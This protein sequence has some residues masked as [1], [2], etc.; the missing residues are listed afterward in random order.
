M[1][2][3]FLVLRLLG[4]GWNDGG[5]NAKGVEASHSSLISA[6]S[7]QFATGTDENHYKLC[8]MA[9]VPSEI[10]TV[11]LPNKNLDQPIRNPPLFPQLH[12]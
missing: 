7:W 4:V 12:A 6:L 1:Q 10:R 11:H 2:R 9:R 5:W 3:R 8:G